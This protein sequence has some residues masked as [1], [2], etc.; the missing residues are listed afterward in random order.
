MKKLMDLYDICQ[1][2]D[3]IKIDKLF[4]TLVNC[5]DYDL[6]LEVLKEINKKYN[7]RVVFNEN[8]DIE[9]DL[10]LYLD[11]K[12]KYINFENIYYDNITTELLNNERL[13]DYYV[14]PITKL[15][16]EKYF[17]KVIKLIQEYPNLD[18]NKKYL[19][20]NL[21]DN[22]NVNYN[23]F[24]YNE[25]MLRYLE[26]KNNNYN[27]S[28]DFLYKVVKYFIG[29][30]TYEKKISIGFKFVKISDIAN[31]LLKLQ[32]KKF[33]KQEIELLTNGR[34]NLLTKLKNYKYTLGN[35]RYRSEF[36]DS[37]VEINIS[38]FIG[39]LRNKRN[40]L[41]I[42]LDVIFHEARHAFQSCGKDLLL[43]N[44][45]ERS[46]VIL[47]LDY[48]YYLNNHDFIVSEIDA[49]LYSLEKRKEIFESY[50]GNI[51][52][53]NYHKEKSEILID[54]YDKKLE[55]EKKVDVLLIE[56]NEEIS[57][58]KT[59]FL[60]YEQTGYPKDIFII[61][62]DKKNNNNIIYNE[63][64]IRA[65]NRLEKKSYI[66]LIDHL[67]ENN[68]SYFLMIDEILK[69]KVK[70]INLDL[71]F[72]EENYKGKYEEKVMPYV[73]QIYYYYLELLKIKKQ[74]RVDKSYSK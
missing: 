19:I 43:E 21:I 56:N 49:D 31:D 39:I 68:E 69:N 65:L 48:N 29:K 50:F 17:L 55:I 58:Y 37:I 47:N 74:N 36:S 14:K 45:Y 34:K 72:L 4:I 61:L 3:K 52:F 24:Y 73:S 41:N 66:K 67:K 51:N 62:N 57:K 38:N 16:K 26:M 15:D 20:E 11:S 10:K 32:K 25:L 30:E 7:N 64:V 46:S 13:Y 33:P 53:N 60:E 18:L 70:K 22:I 44:E 6:Y 59:L 28:I 2:E 5:N 40:D 71:L 23:S 27:L 8:I 63:I 12:Y 35:Q 9:E 1:K 54:H 42:L